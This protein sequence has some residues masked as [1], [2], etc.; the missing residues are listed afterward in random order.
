MK[1]S[2]IKENIINKTVDKTFIESILKRTY[3]PFLEKKLIIEEL[4]S[5][6]T[7]EENGLI[8]VDLFDKQLFTDLKILSSYFD[9]ENDL[10]VNELME[11]Y[12]LLMKDNCFSIFEQCVKTEWDNDIL[13]LR[14]MLESSLNE[15]VKNNNSLE[16]IVAKGINK[17]IDKLPDEKGMSKLIKDLP[18]QVNK[19]DPDKLKYLSEVIGW[20]NGTKKPEGESK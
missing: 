12:D 11:L 6:C 14:E 3:I 20:N 18:K 9:V 15:Y 8:K 7:Y 19:V 13:T 10:E 2:E 4:I 1:Y 17:L 5:I 16:G